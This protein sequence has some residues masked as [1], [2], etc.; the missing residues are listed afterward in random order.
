VVPDELLEEELLDE[1][2]PVPPDDGLPPPHPT[3]RTHAASAPP[4]KLSNLLIAY[5]I[6]FTSGC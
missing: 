6:F 3:R 4:V 5:I 1:L 2:F